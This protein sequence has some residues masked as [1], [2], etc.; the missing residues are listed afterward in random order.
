M[1]QN[2]LFSE[3]EKGPRSR[4][5][6]EITRSTWAGIIQKI[7]SRIV[8]GSFGFRFPLQCPDGL[9][10]Y[11]CDEEQLSYAIIGENP[12]I[13]WPLNAK[14]LPDTMD[15]LDLIEFCYPLIAR[16]I[17]LDEHPYLKH[18]HVKFASTEGRD[19]FR[20]D[21]NRVFSRNGLV[22][23]MDDSGRIIRL[24]S[25]VLHEALTSAV[26]NT[27]DTD[28]DSLLES[29]RRKFLSPD[30]EIRKESLEKLWDAWERLKTIESG[31]NKKESIQR[32]LRK[33]SPEPSFYERL[34]IEATQL[35][36]IGNTYRIRHSE[37]SQIPIETF[38]HVDYLFHRLF[39]MII[40]LLRASK[41][42]S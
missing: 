27:G 6:E 35:T 13:S 29:A 8:D 24:S 11:G 1:N 36:E 26:F 20:R 33:A 9:G 18:T 22:Y 16:P 12:G 28:L 34:D 15:I 14:E 4:V 3:R 5:N 7:Q 37:V 25:P 31:K 30:L 10:V 21:I 42:H 19:V 41:R 32:L 17:D 38:E 23:E 2:I 40:M 39:A